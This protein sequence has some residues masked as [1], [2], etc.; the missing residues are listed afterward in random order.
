MLYLFF[1]RTLF[2]NDFL[3]TGQNALFRLWYGERGK[4]GVRSSQQAQQ[5]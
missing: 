1:E 4:R 5:V 3:K 2:C